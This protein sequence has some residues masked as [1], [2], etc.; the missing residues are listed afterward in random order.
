MISDRETKRY[1]GYACIEINTTQTSVSSTALDI[2]WFQK[3]SLLDQGICCTAEGLEHPKPISWKTFYVIIHA[4]KRRT[5]E[6]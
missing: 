3:A 5:I 6:L 4:Q 2:S 1:H